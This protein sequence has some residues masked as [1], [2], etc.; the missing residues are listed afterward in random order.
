M[1]LR[2]E[3]VEA[4]RRE[5]RCGRRSRRRGRSGGLERLPPPAQATLSAS[6]GHPRPPSC[7]SSSPRAT[8]RRRRGGRVASVLGQTLADLEL[9]SSTTARS[10][11]TPAIAGGRRGTRA[12]PG[13][14]ER[15]T[16]RPRGRAERRARRGA[17]TATSRGMD[18]D[19]VALPRLARDAGRGRLRPDRA[20]PCVGSGDDRPAR[21]TVA[22]HR[23]P[24]ARPAR[25]AVRWA[26]L[27]SVAVLPLDACSSTA[28]CSTGT[29]LRYDTSFRESE[30]YD[31]WA[32]AARGRRRR[33]RAGARS[34]S[35]AGT[36]AGVRAARRAA[37]RVPASGCAAADPGRSRPSSTEERA[38]LAWRAGRGI[39]LP[40]G[41]VRRGGGRARGARR[42]LREALT[43][44]ARARGAPRHGRS[45][46]AR[47]AS[48]RR[49]RR[50]ARGAPCGSTPRSRPGS[51][52]AV[53]A[54]GRAPAAR[55]QLARRQRDVADRRRRSPH[56]RP[57][58][59]DALPD[60]DARP[61]GR[62]GPT[63]TS[64]SSTPG[65]RSSA[66][67]GTSTLRHRA[68][69]VD[70][71]RVPGAYRV[72]RHDYPL[73]LGVFRALR[74]VAARGRRRLG[75]EHVRLAGDRGVVQADTACRTSCSSRATSATRGP[76]WRRR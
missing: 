58:G 47:R 45:P 39:P 73:S 62:S 63:S 18:A 17:R 12:A 43:A 70:G 59:A 66:G 55:E 16:P 28:T 61:P 30:D 5:R 53:S 21:R 35:T 33:Q 65:S 4:A 14:P 19:D 8:P 40:D 44:R 26:A 72:L 22:R 37:V 54:A 9:S 48:R 42:A 3:R 23:A 64:R 27:F 13:R 10:T 57:A 20:A 74:D 15:R 25:D 49:A 2:V 6:R 76:G 11:R 75:L 24:D 46:E 41:A 56:D 1:G 31:L 68:V 60:R 29:A 52:S 38:E 71:R 69:L 50:S 34:C 51:R 36:D 32:R 7:P 67:R